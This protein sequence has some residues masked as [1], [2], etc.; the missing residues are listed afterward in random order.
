VPIIT[1]QSRIC[2][3]EGRPRSRGGNARLVCEV[4][5]VGLLNIYYNS[6]IYGESV[7]THTQRKC[8]ILVVSRVAFRMLKRNISVIFRSSVV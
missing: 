1:D 5:V 2:P 4:S 7:K 3:N 8:V 6:V